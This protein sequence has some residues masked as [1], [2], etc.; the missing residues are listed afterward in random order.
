MEMELTI[1]SILLGT[2]GSG[3]ATF[4]FNAGDPKEWVLE[5]PFSHTGSIDEGVRQAATLLAQLAQA[6]AEEALALAEPAET[7]T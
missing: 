5:I 3:L 7:K 1:D 4:R 2:N 6:L